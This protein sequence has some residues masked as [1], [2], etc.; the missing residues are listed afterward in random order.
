ME[1]GRGTD[2]V[3]LYCITFSQDPSFLCASSDKASVI[4]SLSGTPPRPPLCAGS[5]GPGQACDRPVRGLSVEPGESPVPAEP[6]C[7]CT[8][9]G[10][11]SK[12]VSSIA[13][14]VDGIF[15]RYGFPPDGN[16]NRGFR[17]VPYI[18]DD[19]DFSGACGLC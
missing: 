1:L 2:S 19:D 17:C 16:C 4:P 13:I 12:D 18:S 9:G 5:P 6:A 15:H 3:T 10:S 11:P 7:V 14:C 8:F